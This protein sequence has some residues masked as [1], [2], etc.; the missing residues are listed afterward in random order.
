MQL[1]EKEQQLIQACRKE[2]R[3]WNRW[4]LAFSVTGYSLI[5][6]WLALGAKLDFSVIA[7]AAAYY[8]IETGINERREHSMRKL[9]LKVVEE[10]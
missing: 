7:L 2:E 8:L 4:A 5:G 1:D 10:K 6:L 9:V 3:T